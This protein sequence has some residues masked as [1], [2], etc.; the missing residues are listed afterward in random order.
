M[1]EIGQPNPLLV[2]A[3]FEHDLVQDAV[4]SSTSS[5]EP[6]VGSMD[7][8]LENERPTKRKKYSEIEC[9]KCG[10]LIPCQGIIDE[11]V[12]R[13]YWLEQHIDSKKC[14]KQAKRRQT[15]I[16]KRTAESLRIDMLSG[17]GPHLSRASSTAPSETPTLVAFK[18]TSAASRIFKP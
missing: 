15:E 17:R 14:V 10:A 7:A 4:N 1:S 16:A 11:A 13:N 2:R 9:P 3:V 5:V 6:A 8:E 12:G 18:S